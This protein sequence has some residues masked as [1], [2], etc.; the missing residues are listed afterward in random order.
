[1]TPK[2]ALPTTTDP[3]GN[4]SSAGTSPRLDASV[5]NRRS[6]VRAKRRRIVSDPESGET[7]SQ[8]QRIQVKQEPI[9]SEV[10]MVDMTASNAA[11]EGAGALDTEVLGTMTEVEVSIPATMPL[12]MDPSREGGEDSPERAAVESAIDAQDGESTSQAMGEET[13]SG[14]LRK[15]RTYAKKGKAKEAIETTHVDAE[16]PASEAR[17]NILAASR[18]TAAIAA[19]PPAD[20]SMMAPQT[21]T[22]TTR[23][24]LAKS[25]KTVPANTNPSPN[26]GSPF[27]KKRQHDK[28]SIV[29]SDDRMSP[30]AIKVKVEVLD[31][32]YDGRPRITGG[33]D[34]GRNT[35]L[36]HLAFVL[37]RCPFSQKILFVSKASPY[38]RRIESA[39]TTNRNNFSLRFRSSLSASMTF[40]GLRPLHVKIQCTT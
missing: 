28:H 14:T 31:S 1:M 26:S 4:S 38:L 40:V 12:G 35:F 30:E 22:Y 10:T 25:L 29:R 11:G 16:V 39:L 23:A 13:E 8:S 17:G 3:A 7:K 21:T 18:S 32:T 33:D 9:Q 5:D 15:I 24:K 6:G 27:S 36:S 37:T 34:E 19:H 2:H 20:P